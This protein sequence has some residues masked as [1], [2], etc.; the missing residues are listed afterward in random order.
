MRTELAAEAS[1]L[2]RQLGF[3]PDGWLRATLLNLLL[4]VIFGIFL[5]WEKGRDFLDSVILGAYA[6]LGVVF[7]SPA[8]APEFET[9]PTPKRA[10]A[11]VLVA[12]IYG[13]LVS[14]VMLFLGITTVYLSRW[15]RIVVGP[16][17]GSLLE[18]ALFGLALSLAVS[19][20]TVLVSVQYSPGP[21]KGMVRLVFLAL[22]ALFYLRS[23]WLPAV[24]LRGT[25]IALGASLLFLLALW[26]ML[27]ARNRAA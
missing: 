4:I 10:M 23:G 25:A 16:N 5:P 3:H 6:C 11:R 8:A 12:V 17:L 19:M 13:E 9:F 22:L 21:A 20:A 7:A 14:A 18:C 1:D 15:G 26:T 24:A 2:R 27:T